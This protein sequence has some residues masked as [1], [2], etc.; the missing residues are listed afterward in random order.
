MGGKVSL[1]GLKGLFSPSC[2]VILCYVALSCP[3]ATPTL[4]YLSR[5]VGE[6]V[7]LGEPAIGGRPRPQATQSHD[8]AARYGRQGN[9]QLYRERGRVT[10]YTERGMRGC[11]GCCQRSEV[12]KVVDRYLLARQDLGSVTLATIS[13]SKQALTGGWQPPSLL[14]SLKQKEK[15]ENVQQKSSTKDST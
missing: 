10:H 15:E 3:L 7:P 6:V 2:W 14:S 12:R 13:T 8:C 9:T 5:D 1:A 4:K 11:Q